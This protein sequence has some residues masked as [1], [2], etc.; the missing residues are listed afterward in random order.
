[1]PIR[2]FIARFRLQ[3]A[4]CALYACLPAFATAWSATPQGL[5]RTPSSA[6]PNGVISREGEITLALSACPPAVAPDAAV[7]VLGKTGYEKVRDG[8]NGFTAIVQHSVPGAQEPRCMD[9]EGTRTWLPRILMVAK[10]RAEGKSSEEIQREIAEAIS[11]GVL[12][13]PSRPGVDYMLSSEN[14]VPNEK[15]IVT[16]FPP[17]VMF[18]APYATNADIGV[19]RNKLGADGNPVGPAFVAGEGSPYALIIVPVGQHA[20]M[21]HSMPDFDSGSN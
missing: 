19:D 17:H 11:K 1:M 20:S 6:V 2:F 9:A 5:A 10:L 14:R 3:T 8:G 13:P 12:K 4:A 16:P 18:Y 15:G 21:R 7:Y